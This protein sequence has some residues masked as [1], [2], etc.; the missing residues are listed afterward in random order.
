MPP[1]GA[2]DE[3]RGAA[4]DSAV[5]R[6][7]RIDMQTL[8]VFPFLLPQ[9]D[10]RWDHGLRDDRPIK[11]LSKSAWYDAHVPACVCPGTHRPPVHDFI[12]CNKKETEN[13]ETLLHAQEPVAGA[14]EGAAQQRLFFNPAYSVEG[15]AISGADLAESRA[16]P[17]ALHTTAAGEPVVPPPSD[18]AY[19]PCPSTHHRE[20]SA[21]D[22]VQLLQD[23]RCHV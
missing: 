20:G 12:A 6:M 17:A 22:G 9:A 21:R 2:P 11:G 23:A 16:P 1:G 7:L 8:Q 19:A 4:S 14:P 10:V 18:G 13:T 15:S 5:A 3:A